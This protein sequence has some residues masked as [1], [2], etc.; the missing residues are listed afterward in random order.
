L[1]SQCMIF[2][3]VKK[4]YFSTNKQ[5]KNSCLLSNLLLK[6][7]QTNKIYLVNLTLWNNMFLNFI[8]AQTNKIYQNI[9]LCVLYPLVKFQLV[10]MFS[11]KDMSNLIKIVSIHFKVKLRL[12]LTRIIR[13]GDRCT[14]V[15]HVVFFKLQG[16]LP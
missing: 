7:P 1:I 10:L 4:G 8:W 14:M 13:E 16:C 6:L 5:K 2:V 11:L 9:F 15:A 3:S 12:D